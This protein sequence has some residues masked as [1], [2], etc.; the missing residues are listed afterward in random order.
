MSTDKPVVVYGVS[1]YT[2]R[3]ICEYLRELGV[4]FVA[5]GRDSE[6]IIVMMKK[7]PAHR[8]QR[9]RDHRHREPSGS[10]R[11]G[12]GGR[13]GSSA[14]P[15]ARSSSSGPKWSRPHSRSA[16]TIWIRRESRTGCCMP[17]T[18]GAISSPRPG[19]LLAPGVAHMYTV[20]EIA[21][22]IALEPGGY[23]TLDILVLWKGLPT[24]A[25]TQTI[26]T[27]LKADW[28]YLEQ[29]KLV[30]W[31]HTSAFDV[32]VPGYH[33][34]AIAVPWGGMSHPIWFQNDPRV[35]QR[36][37]DRRG[38]QSSGHGR[39]R[40]DGEDVRG[41]AAAARPGGAG[42]GPGRHRRVAASRHAA[43]REPAHEPVGGLGARCW[44]RSGG[45]TS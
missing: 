16:R 19:L 6:H 33:E 2:G 12:T 27:I 26:F 24:Y 10:P 8:D 9:L 43:A 13:A 29:N 44:V 14:T 41:A 37:R 18:R 40:A 23:D 31:D 36:A 45:L 20:S 17:A 34:L 21:A 3:L 35:S 32:P 39:R 11:G 1:G 42:E 7:L 25:S 28:F 15:P 30:E 38:A 4:P 22:N 5:A